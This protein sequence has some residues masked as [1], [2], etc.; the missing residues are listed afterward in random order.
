MYICI[1][2][3]VLLFEGVNGTLR[4][5]HAARQLQEAIWAL[6][7]GIIG[8]AAGEI[9][10]TCTALRRSTP[11][12]TSWQQSKRVPPPYLQVKF[13]LFFQEFIKSSESTWERFGSPKGPPGDPQEAPRRPPGDLPRLHEV[14]R[15]PNI[16]WGVLNAFQ[17][18]QELP[19]E[20]FKCNL[21]NNATENGVIFGAQK[22]QRIQTK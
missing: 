10:C 9:G 22:E 6:R 14:H 20:R 8:K 3:L 7:G 13:H 2:L 17:K 18:D 5:T 21:Q 11:Q 16:F 12:N 4:E 19:S 15:A 1:Y